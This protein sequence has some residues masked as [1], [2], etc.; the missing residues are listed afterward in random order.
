MLSPRFL[1]PILIFFYIPAI[2]QQTIPELLL[3][4]KSAKEDT[5]QV[6]LLLNLGQLYYQNKQKD[7]VFYYL[8][9]GLELAIKVDDPHSKIRMYNALGFTEHNYGNPEQGVKTLLKAANLLTPSQQFS[10][11]KGE[12][13][14]NLGTGYRRLSQVD[15][16]YFYYTEADK[17]FVYRK[18][19]PRRWKV[20]IGLTRLFLE[21]GEFEKAVNYAEQAM[22]VVEKSNRI[23]YGYTLY[24]M[25]L[26]YLYGEEVEKYADTFQKWFEFQ[27]SDNNKG[28]LDN[29]RHASLIN[30]FGDDLVK[31]ESSMRKALAYTKSTDNPMMIGMHYMALGK[32]LKQAGKFEEA[33]ETYKS[34]IPFLQKAGIRY[35]LNDGYYEIYFLS[36][37]QQNP[38]QAIDF[39][40]KHKALND[41]LFQAK[42][43]TN[44]SELEIKYE[45]AK[46]D[47]AI[48]Q[49]TSERNLVLISSGLLLLLGLSIILFLRNRLINNRQIAAKE[50]E[51]QIQ[52]IAQL[53]QEKK[54]LTYNAMINGQ[55]QERQRIAKDLHDGIGGLLS[56]VKAH[57]NAIQDEVTKLEKINIYKKTNNL[58]DEACEEVRRISHD[59]MPRTLELSGLNLAVEDL[60]TSLRSK[61][62]TCDL[63]IIGL[64]DRLDQN[65]E[66]MI[67]R[68]L[69]E[70][71]NNIIK[72][73]QAKNVLLHIIKN[74]NQLSIL[75]ED[76]GIG[77]DLEK[78][79]TAQG[80]GLKS[81][82][83][84]I[85]F[86]DGTINFDSIKGEGT[87]VNIDI[88]I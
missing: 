50:A 61:G 78:A 57:F 33:I 29:E 69:Q 25:N 76:D 62:L 17:I 82:R 59:M 80:I 35:A 32:I 39:L 74:G 83:S 48:I 11:I 38:E 53:E 67:Y 12:V 47:Q 36:K 4:L 52:K 18:D 42:M 46:K 37:N 63:E 56:T 5:T 73:A 3:N 41:S 40:E 22:E 27:N 68:S 85:K 75:V 70:L 66:T 79:E 44:L 28:N 26:A 55:E 51:L 30:T 34:G 45:T 23:N 2:A 58:I 72:H 43:N 49:T 24:F 60:A 8:N 71:C 6:N 19:N 88:P 54:L 15:S 84:R 87:T 16:A 20:L 31:S 10:L 77:F 86:L 7:S 14:T 9:K 1:I 64:E 13:F 81:I 21:K 65:K